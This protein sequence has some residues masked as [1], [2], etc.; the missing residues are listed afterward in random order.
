MRCIDADA[1]MA[2]MKKDPLYHLVEIYGIEGVIDAEPTIEPP[3]ELDEWCTDCSEYDRERNCCPRYNRVIRA[4][5]E[6]VRAN[7][8]P[9]TGRWYAVTKEMPEPGSRVLVYTV[10]YE[11]HV[12]DAMPNR[13]DNYFW[14]DEEGLCH[15]KWQAEL[16]M[17]LPEV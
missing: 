3:Y 7:F 13:A 17:P 1:L 12:W 11:Y 16:W 4:A 6:E 10:G 9:K 5:V 15:D 14:E 2:R 8:E